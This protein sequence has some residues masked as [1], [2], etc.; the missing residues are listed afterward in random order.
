MLYS[1]TAYAERKVDSKW[2]TAVFELKSVNHRYLELYFKLPD[3]IKDLE[4]T[5]REMAKHLGRGKVDC[6]LRFISPPKHQELLS[7]DFNLIGQLVKLT[8]QV[9]N[10]LPTSAPISLLEVLQWPNV[11]IKPELDASELSELQNT[12]LQGFNKTIEDLMQNRLKEGQA[13]FL[14]IQERINKLSKILEFIRKRL[15]TVIDLYRERLMSKLNTLAIEV[16]EERF[17]QELIY[18]MTKLDVD[19]ELDR[20]AMHLNATQETIEK[21]GSVGRRLDFLMQELNREANTLGSKS[22][23]AEVS[24]AVI[25]LKVVVEQMREQI[26]NLV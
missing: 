18:M 25:E 2:G 17:E 26:Q 6:V 23:D 1:M 15:P 20:F 3:S 21:G 9:K 13:V 4:N 14:L 24:H 8:D 19:E 11:I 16:N 10:L 12:L 5:F 7:A 22:I